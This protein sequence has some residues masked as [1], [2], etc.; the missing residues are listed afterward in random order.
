MTSEDEAK[1]LEELKAFDMKVSQ[2]NKQMD[3]MKKV[4]SYFRDPKKFLKQDI[5]RKEKIQNLPVADRRG[6]KV[7]T[8]QQ[9]LE[10][11]HQTLPFFRCFTL[12]LCYNSIVSKVKFWI[13][14]SLPISYTW[15][16]KKS[17]GKP[18]PSYVPTLVTPA[19]NIC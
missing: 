2:I 7:Y 12:P 4:G 19:N 8:N 10:R 3:M 15:E 11:Y 17:I 14:M 1:E 6:K 13:V 18:L 5:I 16:A 9:I